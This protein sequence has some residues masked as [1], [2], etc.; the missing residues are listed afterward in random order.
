MPGGEELAFLRAQ[1]SRGT[2]NWLSSVLQKIAVAV[3]RFQGRTIRAPYG[4]VIVS[5]RG[6]SPQDRVAR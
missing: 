3:V 5:Q 1:F 4:A 2:L 6:S